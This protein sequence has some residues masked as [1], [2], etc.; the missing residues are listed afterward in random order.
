MLL[1]RIQDRIWEETLLSDGEPVLLCSSL[2]PQLTPKEG[3][4]Q[5]RINRYYGHL[6]ELFQRHCTA[7]LF[8]LA[9]KQRQQARATSHPF[10]P[11]RAELKGESQLGDILAVTLV[12]RQFQGEQVMFSR[13]HREAWELE[14][15]F[16]LWNLPKEG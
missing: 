1:L 15:G 9:E 8:P 7:Q 2:L 16:P 6:E 12:Y 5:E 14:K 13:Q 3:K 11:W 10:D 4:A